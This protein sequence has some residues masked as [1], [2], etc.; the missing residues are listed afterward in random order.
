MKI[1][2]KYVKQAGITKKVS[3]HSLRHT[4]ATYKAKQGV[5]AF[6][7]KDWMGH[8]HIS[9]T[10]LYVHMGQ[11]DAHRLMESTGLPLE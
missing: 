1:V 3:C 5:N 6:Q 9:T 8:E 4:F 10:Q 7:L 2:E 11:I